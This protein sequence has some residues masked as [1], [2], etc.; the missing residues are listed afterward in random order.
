MMVWNWLT[1][2]LVCHGGGLLNR[3]GPSDQFFIWASSNVA[4]GLANSLQWFLVYY[5]SVTDSI[6]ST[7]T[8]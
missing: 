2:Y 3:L 8:L 6:H 1:A 5:T 7:A 4:T